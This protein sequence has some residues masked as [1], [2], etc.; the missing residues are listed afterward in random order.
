VEPIQALRRGLLTRGGQKMRDRNGL[1]RL[2]YMKLMHAVE[3]LQII[4][5]DLL[6]DEAEEVAAR[7]A[8]P[9]SLRRVRGHD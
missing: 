3:L 9:R 7:L 6:A 2:S 4:G 8:V 1:L 5:E